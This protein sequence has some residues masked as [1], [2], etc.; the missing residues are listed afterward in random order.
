[1][2]DGEHELLLHA[3]RRFLTQISTS[4]RAARAIVANIDLFKALAAKTGSPNLISFF[5]P[6]FNRGDKIACHYPCSF[7]L[8]SDDTRARYHGMFL[9]HTDVLLVITIELVVEKTTSDAVSSS[10]CLCEPHY[11]PSCTLCANDSIS[12]D[13]FIMSDPTYVR[14]EQISPLQ[15]RKACRTNLHDR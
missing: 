1:M 6:L 5:E 2:H 12:H 4:S 10:S 15:T 13:F 9:H 14:F 8:Y 3:S 11:T 7:L